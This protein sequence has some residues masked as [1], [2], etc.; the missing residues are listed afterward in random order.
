LGEKTQGFPHNLF[1]CLL[2]QESGDVGVCHL[3]FNQY[4]VSS[5]P[6]SLIFWIAILPGASLFGELYM[7]FHTC[8]ARSQ[9]IWWIVYEFSYTFGQ[10]SAYL[11]N[12]I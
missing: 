5:I 3:T 8:L 1:V 6:F 9:P 12:C 4:G 2:F 11:V 7:N 10:V